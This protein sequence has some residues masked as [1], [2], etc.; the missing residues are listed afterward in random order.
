M[1]AAAAFALLAALPIASQAQPAAK[2]PLVGLLV[3]FGCEGTGIPTFIAAGLLS[4]GWIDGK[5]VTFV[6]RGGGGLPERMP[7]AAT[8][9]AAR[10]LGIGISTLEVRRAAD[11]DG[12]LQALAQQLPDAL[13]S[14]TDALTFF[15]AKRVADFALAHRLPTIC[16]F[17]EMAAAGCLI[18]Y[19]PSF[20]EFYQIN[21]RQIDRILRGAKAGDMPVEQATRYEMAVN[22]KTA[23]ALGITVP[24]SVRVRADEVIE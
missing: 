18:S 13:L 11:Y 6:C 15:N 14:F 10:A 5:T 16:E 2:L 17:K 3:P 4:L 7:A 23:R 8:M 22:L 9:A 19:G 24:Q 21:A 12:V 20:A 1:F